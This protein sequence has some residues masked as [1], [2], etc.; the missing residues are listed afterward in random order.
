MKA[1]INIVLNSSKCITVHVSV[2]YD[3][4]IPKTY[5]DTC[6]IYTPQQWRRI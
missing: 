2:I 4:D 5:H 3:T 6:I 1:L